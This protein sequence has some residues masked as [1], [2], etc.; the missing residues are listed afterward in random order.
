MPNAQAVREML[1]RGGAEVEAQKVVTICLSHLPL[2][3][4]NA[5]NEVRPNGRYLYWFE[6]EF[7]NGYK[8]EYRGDWNTFSAQCVLVYDLMV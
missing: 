3:V 2:R 7:H 1:R 4:R 6:V 8:V 5:I